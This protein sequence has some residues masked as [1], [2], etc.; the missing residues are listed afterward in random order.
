MYCIH[1]F[2]IVIYMRIN[3]SNINAKCIQKY[4][5]RVNRNIVMHNKLV[6]VPRCLIWTK[7]SFQFNKE[8]NKSWLQLE[9]RKIFPT[10]SLACNAHSQ[11]T[12]YN[13]TYMYIQ[14]SSNYNV[15][16]IVFIYGSICCER[17]CL[18][19]LPGSPH[20]TPEHLWAVPQTKVN[21]TGIWIQTLQSHWIQFYW[22]FQSRGR[23]RVCWG[24]YCR[25]FPW[26]TS[27]LPAEWPPFDPLTTHP[28]SS[29]RQLWG[30]LHWQPQVRE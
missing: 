16:L 8:S 4:N 14:C 6:G 7:T 17:H 9:E 20:L 27:F 15:G 5:I 18:R 25:W 29:P 11:I 13:H 30:S 24:R 10:G 22:T 12:G 2:F 19:S 26:Q 21:R 23:L 28:A 3:I 1:V